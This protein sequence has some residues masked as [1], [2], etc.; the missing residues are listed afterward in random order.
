MAALAFIQSPLCPVCGL[1][2]AGAGRDHRC[3]HCLARPPRYNTARACIG[4]EAGADRPAAVAA[5]LH[6]YK[7]ARDVTLAPILGTL[8]AD[9]YGAHS[10]HDV[11]VP[12]PLHIR[13]LRWRGFNQALLLARPLA[14]RTRTA[15]APFALQRTRPTR[16][17]VGL[18]EL[19]RRRN[20]ARAFGVRHPEQ[21]HGRSVLLVDDVYTTGATVNECAKTL[22]HAGATRVDV[23]VLARAVPRSLS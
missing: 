16:P 22:R 5:M 3:A 10:Q 2:F 19:G 21:V 6:R 7:Y 18:D 14:R 13:R 9:H 1:P 23:L 4:Y 11:I 20:I 15:L 17:Q 8:L 12:V